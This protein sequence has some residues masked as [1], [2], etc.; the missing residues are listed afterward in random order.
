M[1]RHE[2]INTTDEI[3]KI[4]GSRLCMLST[5]LV[6]VISAASHLMK[7][8]NE[9]RSINLNFMLSILALKLKNGSIICYWAR[10]FFAW[11]PRNLCAI[12]IHLLF[13]NL[14]EL[15]IIQWYWKDDYYIGEQ[16][17]FMQWFLGTEFLPIVQC[18]IKSSSVFYDIR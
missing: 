9:E 1:A 5:R 16:S 18:E 15:G 17:I 13:S 14:S 2:G 11:G 10:K 4:Y 8:D 12:K 6:T 3:L 7:N